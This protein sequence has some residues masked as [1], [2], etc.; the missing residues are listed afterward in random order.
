MQR[1]YNL[2]L[3]A[4][5]IFKL[6][7]V[8]DRF[9]QFLIVNEEFLVNASHQLALITSLPFVHTAR[10]TYRLN[11]SVRASDFVIRPLLGESR[12]KLS[13]PHHLEEGEVVTRFP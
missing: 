3:A 7:R 13:K 1:V 5:V 2:G 12:E 9:L 11:G 4:W 8:R 10:R 6:Y